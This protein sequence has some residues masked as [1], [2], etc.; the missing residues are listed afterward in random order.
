MARRELIREAIE[1]GSIFNLEDTTPVREVLE[2]IASLL[3]T[4]QLDERLLQAYFWV[5]KHG[6]G[7]DQYLDCTHFLARVEKMPEFGAFYLALGLSLELP[8]NT[9]EPQGPKVINVLAAA[10]VKFHADPSF[11]RNILAVC[12]QP[13]QDTGGLVLAIKYRCISPE[14]VPAGLIDHLEWTR[15]LIA[16]D[17]PEYL[18]RRSNSLVDSGLVLERCIYL[19]DKAPHYWE[20]VSSRYHAFFKKLFGG[21]CRKGKR[22]LLQQ[23]HSLFPELVDPRVLNLSAVALRLYDMTPIQR[24]YYLGYP[25]HLGTPGEDQ[26]LA[27]LSRLSEIGAEAYA[28]EIAT[29][30]REQLKRRVPSPFSLAV[31][32]PR[33]ETDLLEQS[34]YDY[35]PFDVISYEEAGFYHV[36]TRPEFSSLLKSQKNHYTQT[37]LPS[38]VLSELAGRLKFTRDAKLPEARP[39]SELLAGLDREEIPAPVPPVEV[40]SRSGQVPTHRPALY[41]SLLTPRDSST[42]NFAGVVFQALFL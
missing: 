25:V 24:A 3:E 37:S 20:V 2:V 34:V 8:V 16:A 32:A 26:L 12:G 7:E 15:M 29:F 14:R 17:I 41:A 40:M 22:T 31:E 28:A 1:Y 5:C 35:S 27:A 11:R 21:K 42:T 4:L 33:N 30:Q 23:L 38:Y 13:P 18:S 6:T 9:T 10:L 36:F 39:L 19:R